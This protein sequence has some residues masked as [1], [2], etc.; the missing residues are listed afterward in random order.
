MSLGLSVISLIAAVRAIDSRRNATIQL[1]LAGSPFGHPGWSTSP[2][3]SQWEVG[4]HS[5]ASRSETTKALRPTSV[6]E[7]SELPLAAM[8]AT[9]EDECRAE[10]QRRQEREAAMIE[11]IFEENLRMQEGGIQ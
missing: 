6:A 7:L 1:D 9:C 2:P 10:T 11:Q 3:W 5:R 4:A 8:G